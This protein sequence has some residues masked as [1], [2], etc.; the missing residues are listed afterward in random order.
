MDDKISTTAAYTASGT[1]AVLGMSMNEA[2][3]AVGI[4]CAIGTFL[5]NFWFKYQHLKLARQRRASDCQ[6]YTEGEA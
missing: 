5:V 2:A 3:A 4:A 6:A 1:A